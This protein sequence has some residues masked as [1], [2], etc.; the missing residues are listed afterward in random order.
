MHDDY[1]FI[2]GRRPEYLILLEKDTEFIER[3]SFI[4]EWGKNILMEQYKKEHSL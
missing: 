2:E 4:Y 3:T 1:S